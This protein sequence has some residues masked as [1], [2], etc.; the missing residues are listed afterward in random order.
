MVI[1]VTPQE[2]FAGN[3]QAVEI[4]ERVHS[5]ASTVGSID[6]RVG[7]SQVALR[8]RTGFAYLWR[9]GQYLAR[10]QA[11]LVLTIALGRHDRS[12]KFKQVVHPSAHHWMHHLEITSIDDIDGAVAAWIREAA[13]RAG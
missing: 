13:G 7:K 11:D 9:P 1:G 5:I 8:R 3:E 4:F 12:P 2:F 10:P 6:V